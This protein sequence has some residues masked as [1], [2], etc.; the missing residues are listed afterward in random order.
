MKSAAS[1][2]LFVSAA[3]CAAAGSDPDPGAYPH[4]DIRREILSVYR[5]EATAKEPPPVIP[6]P[7]RRLVQA[8]SQEV[9]APAPAPRDTRKMNAL[10]A[11]IVQEEA[12]A[13][14]AASASRLGIGVRSVQ[15]GRHLVA[16]AATV[17][18][19]PVAVGIG[20]IW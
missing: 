17:F 7:A 18:Y 15:L 10:R 20:A 13:R 12:D 4:T 14:S 3:A 6:L 1:L 8:A 11:A 16:G 2:L 19:I 9:L 5:Y